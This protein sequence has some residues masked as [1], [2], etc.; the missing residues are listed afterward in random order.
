MKQGCL[1]DA[2]QH[3]GNAHDLQLIIVR[4]SSICLFNLL[5]LFTA[6][7]LGRKHMV[8]EISLFLY[9]QFIDKTDPMLLLV[10]RTNSKE[11]HKINERRRSYSR[12]NLALLQ[13][14][15]TFHRVIFVSA[16]A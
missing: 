2:H 7:W 8:C 11:I 14:L 5:P 15:S 13:L 4:T 3:Q 1:E 12:Q 16:P 9:M 6:I 10:C